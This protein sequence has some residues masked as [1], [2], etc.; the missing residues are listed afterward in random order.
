MAALPHSTRRRHVAAHPAFPLDLST[1]EG[2]MRLPT[3][4]CP[5]LTGPASASLSASVG[6]LCD[7]LALTDLPHVLALIAKPGATPPPPSSRPSAGMFVAHSRGPQG[8]G[9]LQ[10]RQQRRASAPSLPARRRADQGQPRG[11]ERPRM[12]PAFPFWARC[13][14][15]LHLSSLTT[16][17]QVPHRQPRSQ[18]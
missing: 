4:R 18:G 3:E 17:P 5:R 9:V 2:R 7:R 13:L 8:T 15:H 16:L 11:E 6:S 14:S 10:F 12:A 1:L